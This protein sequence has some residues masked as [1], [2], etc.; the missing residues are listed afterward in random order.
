MNCSLAPAHRYADASGAPTIT[1]ALI[2]SLSNVGNITANVFRVKEGKPNPKRD[3]GV[4]YGPAPLKEV[5]EKALKGLT[6]SHL[7]R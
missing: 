2:E 5:P 4:A 1:N 6:L 3:T 7:S